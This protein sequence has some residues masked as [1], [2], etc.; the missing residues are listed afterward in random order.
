MKTEIR[1]VPKQKV[2]EDGFED[3]EIYIAYDGR[4]FDSK[5]QAIK[6]EDVLNFKKEFIKKYSYSTMELDDRYHILHMDNDSHLNRNNR[7]IRHELRNELR[8]FFGN[9]TGSRFDIEKL[10]KGWNFIVDNET[11]VSITYPSELITLYEKEIKL[12]KKYIEQISNHIN[13]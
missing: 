2:I 3:K 9:Y 11:Y 12:N 13:Q 4:E 10:K 8:Q 5:D 6:Y 1:K 7:L